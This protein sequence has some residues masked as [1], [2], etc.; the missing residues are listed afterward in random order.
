[1]PSY[2][3]RL[4]KYIIVKARR[5]AGG[6]RRITIVLKQDLVLLLAVGT[7]RGKDFLRNS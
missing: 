2:Q 3:I 6:G 4:G 7:L 1:M 5:S